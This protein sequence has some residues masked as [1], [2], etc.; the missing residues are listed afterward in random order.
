VILG[1]AP[2]PGGL[3]WWV[4]VL[5]N[6]LNTALPLC[7]DAPEFQSLVPDS[8]EPSAV[9]ALVTRL[10]EVATTARSYFCRTPSDAV[11]YV[12]SEGM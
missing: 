10:D 4:G 1:R 12:Y 8:R 7:L 6:S 2:D 11:A 9:T 5:L 3:D